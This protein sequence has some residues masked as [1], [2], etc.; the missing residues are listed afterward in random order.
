ML[1]LR[2]VWTCSSEAVVDGWAVEGLCAS[3]A[4]REGLE[5]ISWRSDLDL[6]CKILGNQFGPG[7]SIS[8]A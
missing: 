8:G 1:A 2:A 6:S 4:R 7:S 5:R 3:A